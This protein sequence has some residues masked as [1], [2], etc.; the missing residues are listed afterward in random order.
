L[1]SK[2]SKPHPPHPSLLAAATLHGKNALF[3][4]LASSPKTSP[5]QHSRSHYNAFCSTTCTSMQS[6]QCDLYPLVAEHRRGG[7]DWL[8]NDPNRTRR[9]QEVPF[10]AGCSHFTRINT[11]FRAPAS[12]RKPAPCNIHAAITMRFASNHR[13]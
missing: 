2:R 10:I 9:T 7:T 8:R 4:A 3:R 12:S 6:L 1:T 5:T 11:R 13:P